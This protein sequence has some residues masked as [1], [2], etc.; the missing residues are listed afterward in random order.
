MRLAALGP[1]GSLLVTLAL[2]AQAAPADAK[3]PVFL[4]RARCAACHGNDGKAQ[5]EVGKEAKAADF[6][7][8]AFQQSHTDDSIRKSI[9]D[10]RPG[11]KMLGFAGKLTPDE[12]ESLVKVIRAF[13]PPR[14]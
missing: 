1:A 11:T 5:T 7:T 8:A 3:D 6:T 14:R 4:Y 12:V 13:G 2:L 9:L 10:G